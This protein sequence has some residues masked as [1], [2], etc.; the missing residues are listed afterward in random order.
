MKAI[1]LHARG[2]TEQLVYEDAPKPRP[3]SGD[4]IVHVYAASI[5]PTELSWSTTYTHSD[6]TARIPSIPGHDLSGVVEE[7]ASGVTDVT[8]GE[9]VYA[10]TDFW[11]DGTAAEYVAVRAGDLAPKPHSLD[12]TH[13]AAVP[14]SA[15]TAWQA[16]FIHAGLANDRRV[17]IHG[18]AGGVGTYAVQLAKWRGAYVIATAS[19]RNDGFLRE[20]GADEVIDYTAARF[21]DKV[22]DADVVLDTV[23]G[24]TLDRSWGV[25]RK[26]GVL[27]TTAGTAAEDKAARYGVRGVFFIVEPSRAQL[28]EIGRLIDSGRIRPVVSNV[29]PLTQARDLFAQGLSGHTRGK[30]VLSVFAQ[31]HRAV[32]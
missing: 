23:G 12:H 2:G 30:L 11:R 13:A 14:L 9:E 28:V 21:E 27:V 17:L 20:L 6:G 22:R 15:L 31:E 10:L 26:G 7:V 1:R 5:T 32:A 29:L 16:L 3:G 19:A 8:V 25:L 18:G 4:A 24:D